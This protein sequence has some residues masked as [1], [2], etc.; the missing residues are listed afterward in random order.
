LN[1]KNKRDRR[2][3]W[4]L[5]TLLVMLALALVL[6]IVPMFLGNINQDYSQTFYG[7]RPLIVTSDSMED[8][9][10]EG[11]LIVGR[12]TDFDDLQVGDVITFEFTHNGELTFNTHRVIAIENGHIT[13]QGD[14]SAIADS[15]PVTQDNFAYRVVFH[16]NG[17]AQ[18]GTVR[19]MLLYIGLPIVGLLI[20][21][22]GIVFLIIWSRRRKNTDWLDEEI[23][24][25]PYE[26]Y[27][28]PQPLPEQFA[29]QPQ[30]QYAPQ[31][32]YA[33]APQAQQYTPPPQEQYA[34]HEWQHVPP[35]APQ[36]EQPSFDEED[37]LIGCVDA[38]ISR[39][40]NVTNNEYNE[41]EEDCEWIDCYLGQR[42]LAL[43]PAP[44]WTYSGHGSH[45]Q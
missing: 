6:V 5:N 29:S 24:V 12:V 41:Y 3:N 18:M 16:W 14:N 27:A 33:M 25:L 32:Q 43:Q 10:M 39:Q 22:G 8:Y 17:F 26:S 2:S 4:I 11:A 9:I 19:G 13:T 20:L 40:P 28:M 1:E 15:M 42:G 30:E 7:F 34:Q 36:W 37:Y 35:P 23:P 45:W 31:A 44:S 21:A 38:A